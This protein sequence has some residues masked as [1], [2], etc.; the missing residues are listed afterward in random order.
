MLP[1]MSPGRVLVIDDQ[2]LT[3]KLMASILA[4]EF[5][6]TLADSFDNILGLC[7]SLAPDAI[8]LDVMMPGHDGYEI[9]TQL[10]A[11]PILNHI[12]VLFVTARSSWEDEAQGLQM[13]AADFVTKPYNPASLKARVR[14][15]V[16]LKRQRDYLE[17]LSSIDGLTGIA[18]RRLF[19]ER[20]QREWRRHQRGGYPLGLVLIDIDHFKRY[21]DSC[22]HV[23]GDMC[24]RQVAQIIAETLNRPGDLAAR[25]GGEEFA[26]LLP[27]TDLPGTIIIAN[28]LGEA[29]ESLG[30]HHPDSTVGRSVTISRGAF[31]LIP[32]AS[33]TPETMVISTD[34][35]LYE[36][37]HQG[38]NRT[39][40]PGLVTPGPVTPA[41]TKTAS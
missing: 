2:P 33:A 14:N 17:K 20:F 41:R 16:A 26:C 15:V 1:E 4:E 9:C 22:G 11:D 38:R 29:V 5:D 25:Y 28:R 12:P 7:H 3:A 24:L 27:E 39:G 35:N 6:V 18:N 34:A 36:A 8:L 21:N 13:G 30:I 31:S 23:A 32:T 19:D 10:K 40:A 37:K